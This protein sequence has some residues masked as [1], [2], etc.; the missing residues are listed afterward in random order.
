MLQ[1]R[2]WTQALSSFRVKGGG[3]MAG[4]WGFFSATL[5][6]ITDRGELEGGSIIG[7][8]LVCLSRKIISICLPHHN[9]MIF[10]KCAHSPSR[11]PAPKSTSDGARA[12]RNAGYSW[13]YGSRSRPKAAV[14]GG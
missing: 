11:D 2:G 7:H 1:Y 3:E 6:Q 8:F 14:I 5:V 12:R 10:A 13:P 4:F 9:M